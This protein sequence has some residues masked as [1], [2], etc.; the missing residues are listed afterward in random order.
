MINSVNIG[1]KDKPIII[2]NGEE[3]N[4]IPREGCD[5]TK[6]FSKEGFEMALSID[7]EGTNYDKNLRSNVLNL[8]RF[9]KLATDN[10]IT[11]ILF[12]T[13]IFADMLYSLDLVERIKNNYD[14]IFGLH[15]HPDNLPHE[16]RKDLD[17]IRDDEEF[18][19]NYN[20]EEQEQ[21]ILRSIQYIESRN[22]K[23]LQIFRGGCFSMNN[24]TAEILYSNTDI[25]YESHNPARREYSVCNFLL[26]SIPVY[27]VS[28]DEEIRLEYFTSERLQQLLQ[29]AIKTGSKTLAITHSYMLDPA[30]FHYERDSIEKS[31]YE[32]LELLIETMKENNA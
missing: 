14:V 9:L 10:S 32:R 19:A 29:D 25:R 31:I 28:K 13:P 18:L 15:I 11:T 16:I 12:I 6:L 7:C 2:G 23:P 17:F 26:K 1:L 8:E 5:V 30:D 3:T 27:A 22:V 20:Y 21:I 4:P 24:D